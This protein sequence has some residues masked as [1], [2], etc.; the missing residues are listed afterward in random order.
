MVFECLM[1]VNNVSI[2]L[3]IESIIMK[4]L[5]EAP[6]RYLVINIEI[7]DMNIARVITCIGFLV[8]CS[9]LSDGYNIF[10]L[11][12]PIIMNSKVNATRKINRLFIEENNAYI[13]GIKLSITRIIIV[14]DGF[15]MIF[16]P[17]TLIIKPIILFNFQ[18]LNSL[19]F[20][21][22]IIVFFSKIY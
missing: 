9:M 13:S 2:K 17:P 22:L 3:T 4:F 10:V 11:A 1:L 8:I 7:N 12:N 21:S 18:I 19:L 15:S 20:F 6:R 16:I 14:F 5:V